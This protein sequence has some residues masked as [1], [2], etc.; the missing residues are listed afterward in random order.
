VTVSNPVR[1]WIAATAL[2]LSAGSTPAPAAE[3]AA[4][5]NFG[6]R[7]ASV[8]DVD[9][10]RIPDIAVS[11]PMEQDHGRV[12]LFS[13]KSGERIRS[14]RSGVSV[15]CLGMSLAAAGDLDGDGKGD[16]LAGAVLAD[17][18]PDYRLGVVYAFSGAT[19]K[20]IREFH[21]PFPNNGFGEVLAGV[22]DFNND[23][24]DDFLVSAPSDSPQ[25]T[26]WS[27][28]V[29][30]LSG[31][32]GARLALMEGNTRGERLGR[33]VAAAGDVNG[34]GLPDLAVTG[35][36][37]PLSRAR[38]F[39]PDF[40]RVYSGKDRRVLLDVSGFKCPEPGLGIAAPGDLN[41]DGKADLVLGSA[42]SPHGLEGIT[43]LVRAVSG[44][45]GKALWTAYGK[46]HGEFFGFA[47]AVAWDV[48]GDGVQDI[49]VGAGFGMDD[50]EAAKRSRID[51]LS[52][53][54]GNVLRTLR[55]PDPREFLLVEHTVAALGD[56]D[57][58]GKPEIGA[59]TCTPS[60]GGA[61]LASNVRVFSSKDGKPVLSLAQPRDDAGPGTPGK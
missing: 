6:L 17:K 46:E 7:I 59:T 31:K 5:T 29:R 39:Q 58:D 48:D 56:L 33:T 32:D 49:A 13:G 51:L 54:S 19:G 61:P 36:S 52:G 4:S 2:L 42:L 20:V 27:G 28:V 15:R 38:E 3:G 53:K 10:D 21:D 23:G 37:L 18:G 55:L 45:T 26:E 35:V 9:G 16:V 41:G 11:A 44:G 43:G 40:V 22:G 24:K 14:L 12:H 34:D 50:A 47:V 1:R 8:G 57:G 25:D 30:V 60:S